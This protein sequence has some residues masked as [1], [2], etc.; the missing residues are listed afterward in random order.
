MPTTA[1]VLSYCPSY[2]LA[3]TARVP[4]SVEQLT[5]IFL[6]NKSQCVMQLPLIF[7]SNNCPCEEQLPL[8]FLTS[9]NQ[10]T[11]VTKGAIAVWCR[12][13]HDVH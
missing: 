12:V 3:T 4:E 2:F 6:D 5:I 1:H 9:A 7:F 8:I 13:D 11:A 10:E